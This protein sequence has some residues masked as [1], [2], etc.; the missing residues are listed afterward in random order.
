MAKNIHSGKRRWR[1][2]VL[3]HVGEI[4]AN[5][6]PIDNAGEYATIVSGLPVAVE[7]LTG[8]DAHHSHNIFCEFQGGKD[9]KVDHRI[10]INNQ[11]YEVIGVDDVDGMQ[12]ELHIQMR[13]IDEPVPVHTDFGT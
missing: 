11:T 9:I 12:R 13:K 6:W 8:N 5:G 1:A 10:V 7:S 3:E 4:D 2:D